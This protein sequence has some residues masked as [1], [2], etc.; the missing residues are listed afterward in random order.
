MLCGCDDDS[1]VVGVTVG[2]EA[3]GPTVAGI[4]EAANEGISD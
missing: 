3:E 4:S 1:E 2:K